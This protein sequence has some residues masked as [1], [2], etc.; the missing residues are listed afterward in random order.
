MG[1]VLAARL[2][3]SFVDGDERI[4]AEAGTTIAEIFA[5]EGEAGFRDREAEVLA[6]LCQRQRYVI[7][8]G[9]G[10]V[11]RPANRELL[12]RSGFVVWLTA[13]PEA[14]FAR[15]QT[16]PTTATRR[17]NLTAKAGSTKSEP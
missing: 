17:P 13:S 10:V 5:T 8:T 9:G 1:R 7:A 6:Q 3:W 11:L 2:G 15:L 14:A 4:E 16:D 12:K